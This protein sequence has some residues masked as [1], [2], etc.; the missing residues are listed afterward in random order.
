MKSSS[1]FLAIYGS[2]QSL[3]LALYKEN[4]CIAQYQESKARASSV[5]IPLIDNLLTNNNTNLTELNFI[6]LDVGPGAFTSLRVIISSINGIAYASKIPLITVDGLEA[7]AQTTQMYLTESNTEP[8][9]YHLIAL[10]NAYNQEVYHAHYY[11][12]NENMQLTEPASYTAASIFF[13]TLANKNYHIPL[14]FTGNGSLLHQELISH[15]FKGKEYQ[16]INI[17]HANTESISIIGKNSFI[18]NQNISY[19]VQPLYLKKETFVTI[20]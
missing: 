16:I 3:E 13:E 11:Y 2:Y 1:T 9:K 5:L 6:A 19:E 8:E 10:L 7:L 15:F 4:I 17:P 12:N 20:K 18:K 14:I